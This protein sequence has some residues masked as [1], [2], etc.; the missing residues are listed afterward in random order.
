GAEP[1][2]EP[3]RVRAVS[4]DEL[5]ALAAG[6]AALHELGREGAN[7][8]AYVQDARAV[9]RAGRHR[10]ERAGLDVPQ[11]LGEV[12]LHVVAGVFRPEHL[13]AR[14]GA[15]AAAAHG[16][17]GPQGDRPPDATCSRAISRRRSWTTSPS[18]TSCSAR[19]SVTTTSRRP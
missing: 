12:V 15:A 11:A 7:A 18:A 5:D 19:G 13:L 4:A 8:P 2:G 1:P 6:G 17:S 10:R 3:R 9:G 14:R 16:A